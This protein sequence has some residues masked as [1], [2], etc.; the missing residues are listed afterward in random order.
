MSNRTDIEDGHIGPD[1]P[2]PADIGENKKSKEEPGSDV[3]LDAASGPSIS[4]DPAEADIIDY[5]T[6]TWWY[7]FFPAFYA[8]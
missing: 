1:V 3:G 8:R 6:L 2:R 5:K 7:V 4:S